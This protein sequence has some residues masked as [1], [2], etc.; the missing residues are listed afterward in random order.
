MRAPADECAAWRR[1]MRP[2]DTLDRPRAGAAA[3]A[4]SFIAATLA[5]GCARNLQPG[6]RT[7]LLSLP[8]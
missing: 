8:S 4:G 5:H 6:A 1:V 3:P 7:T 2:G